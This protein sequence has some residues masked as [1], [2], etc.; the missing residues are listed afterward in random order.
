MNRLL[1]RPSFNDYGN[2]I[3]KQLKVLLFFQL[4]QGVGIFF[5]IKGGEINNK[6]KSHKNSTP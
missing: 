6:K 5:G 1:S 2:E 4:A 3:A